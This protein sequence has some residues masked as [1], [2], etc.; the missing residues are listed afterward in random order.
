MFLFAVVLAGFGVLRPCPG[1]L[2]HGCCCFAFDSLGKRGKMRTNA[3]AA[4]FARRIDMYAA[5]CVVRKKLRCTLNVKLPP[6]AQLKI[7]VEVV[8][9]EGGLLSS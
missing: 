6:R 3:G 1:D 8:I 9:G 2:C 5:K 4:L 7:N